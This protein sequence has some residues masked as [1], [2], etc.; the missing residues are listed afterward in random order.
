MY[1]LLLRTGRKNRMSISFEF[2]GFPI[3]HSELRFY[4]V[5]SVFSSWLWVIFKCMCRVTDLP[6]LH[7]C[8]PCLQLIVSYPPS[9]T[10][11]LGFV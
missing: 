8:V 6:E 11:N 1:D 4:N 9:P 7:V 10:V 5:S 3:S 2:S